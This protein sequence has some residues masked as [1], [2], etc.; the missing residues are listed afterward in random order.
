MSTEGGVSKSIAVTPLLETDSKDASFKDNAMQNNITSAAH[1][2]AGLED[3]R[4]S[5]RERKATNKFT[6]KVNDK[7]QEEFK[8]PVGPGT[9]LR[10]IDYL[11]ESVCF[12]VNFAC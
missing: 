11:N 5:G 12:E 4:M 3:R 10:D 6:P 2:G 9:K 1:K 7:E 8:P